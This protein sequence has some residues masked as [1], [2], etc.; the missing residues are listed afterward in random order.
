MVPTTIELQPLGRRDGKI[1]LIH[2]ASKSASCRFS[3]T[4]NLSVSFINVHTPPKHDM[5]KHDR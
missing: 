5:A 1:N 3:K 2:K 4:L